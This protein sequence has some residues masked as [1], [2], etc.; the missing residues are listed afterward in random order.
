MEVAPGFVVASLAV[1]LA[2][3]V[4]QLG[5]AAAEVFLLVHLSLKSFKVVWQGLEAAK[6][7]PRLRDGGIDL[8]RLGL[9]ISIHHHRHLDPAKRDQLARLLH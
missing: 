4:L 3:L 6:Q 7:P 2:Y 1:A 5:D 9:V 8:W